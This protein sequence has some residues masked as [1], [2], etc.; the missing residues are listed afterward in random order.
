MNGL[1]EQVRAEA[2][3]AAL[4]TAVATAWPAD[5]PVKNA[6][7]VSR[8]MVS[9]SHEVATRADALAWFAGLDLEPLHYMRGTFVSLGVLAWQSA[10]DMARVNEETGD[11][12]PM[13][14]HHQACG[15]DGLD[16]C[17]LE[18]YATIGVTRVWLHC[19]ITQDPA[20]LTRAAPS[21]D[22]RDKR[23]IWTLERAPQG[24]AIRYGGGDPKYPGDTKVYFYAEEGGAAPDVAY[25][26]E[27]SQPIARGRH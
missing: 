8:D 18:G 15:R 7:V 20:R 16:R 17:R 9:L 6:C 21:R 5:K 4:L 10:K 22:D 3:K 23:G 26:L 1:L 19:T 11:I 27:G 13:F 24:E 2:S 12:L 14:W 25:F